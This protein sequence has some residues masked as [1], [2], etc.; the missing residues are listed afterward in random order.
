LPA[1]AVVAFLAAAVWL[2]DLVPPKHL[3]FAAGREGGAYDVLAERYRAILARDGIEVEIIETAGSVENAELLAR[4]E[5][6]VDAAFLQGGVN[7]PADARI[8]ALAA[9]FLEPL[10]IFHGGSL[11]DAADPT[12]WEGLRIAGG[13][14]GSGARFVVDAVMRTL[15][16]DPAGFNLMPLAGAEAAEALAAGTVDVALFVAP[17]SAPY[18]QPLIADDGIELAAI[19]DGDAL[20]RRLPFVQIADLPAAAFDYAER[21]PPRQIDLIA[22]VGRLAARSDLHPSL[23]DRL[24]N[25]AREVH[26]GRDLITRTGQFPAIEGTDMPLNAQAANIVSK[27]PSP[28]YR[29]LPYWVVAQV[30]SFALL[31]VPVLVILFPLL[32]AIPGLYE[33]RMR[34]RVYRHYVDL[35]EIDRQAMAAADP[36]RLAELGG[37]LDAIERDLVRMHLPLRFREYSYTLRS[38]IELVRHRILE[39]QAAGSRA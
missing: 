24:A 16:L 20:V 6:P 27:P 29:F 11:H 23:V 32:R 34:S 9:T 38:H 10:W 39:R 30:N 4:P 31:L 22:M 1:V 13:E 18:L 17:V 26:S 7:P 37:R 8:Q 14:P 21:R 19:R 35:L 3:T 15:R 25:A 28:L 36:A 5:G 33:W 12:D 2:L